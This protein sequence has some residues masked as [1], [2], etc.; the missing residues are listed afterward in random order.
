MDEHLARE[1]LSDVEQPNLPWTFWR[2]PVSFVD[3]RED[4]EET[5]QA[6]DYLYGCIR[7]HQN[8][9][10]E[11]YAREQLGREDDRKICR[12]RGS[13]R[14]LRPLGMWVVVETAFDAPG[15]NQTQLSLSSDVELLIRLD[16]GN[17][18]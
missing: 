15:P 3:E 10:D 17:Y 13:R 14:G 7:S 2:L 6:L 18:E 11:L 1:L 9:G 16:I 4:N 12:R 8:E 5:Q